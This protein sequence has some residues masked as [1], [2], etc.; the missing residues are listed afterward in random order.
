MHFR[1]GV[2]SALQSILNHKLRSLLTLTGIVIGVLAVVTMFSS[3]Y[4]LKA[5]I[6]NNMEGMGWNYSLIITPGGES[7][8]QSNLS[9]KDGIRRAKQSIP[10]LNYDD[11]IALR[12]NLKLKSI[13]GMIESS[14]LVRIGN[15]TRN[16]RLRATNTE[17]FIN[18]TYKIG[19]GRYFNEY[20]NENNMAVAVLGYHFAEEYFPGKNPVGEY[21]T[22]GA[23]RF[24]IV[25]VLA[26]DAL[27]SGNGMNFN[28]WERKEDLKA[29]YVPL[30]Y[31]A[32]YLGTGGTLHQ[33]YL[34]AAS[35]AAYSTLKKEARQL[36][37]SRHNMY[38]NF[39][40][41]D[42]GD[43]LLSITDEINKFMKKWNITL[44]AIASISLIV[45][46]I[47]LFSTLLISIQERMSEIGIRKSIGA[48]ETDIFF[49][50]IFEAVAL[51]FCGAVTGVMLAW[52]LITIIA[53]AIH[54]PLF[55]PMQG[56]AVGLSFSLLIGFASG[57]YPALKAASIDPIQAIYYRE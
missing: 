51:A 23:N 16:M 12:D 39:S 33:I 49:Y 13:Y 29:V 2:H 30:K 1:D 45:G 28:T 47:G 6:K 20:E 5:L 4:A 24:R 50:F 48:T 8:A 31:G 38:P 21:L 17:Y 42:V 26:S 41:M 34:Q 40:F 25:G 27:S 54:F 43:F 18:K 53:K 37:L 55:L 56:V 11:F 44:I 32:R 52:L 15:K 35:E 10:N 36:L 7:Y 19:K 46:G 22:L 14:S 57:I 9:A 3:V